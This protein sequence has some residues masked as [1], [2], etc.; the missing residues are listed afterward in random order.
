MASLTVLLSK[1]LEI[2]RIGEPAR[3]SPWDRSVRQDLVTEQ[4]QKIFMSDYINS[5]S[6]VHGDEGRVLKGH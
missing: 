6:S 4:Q 5:E 1:L 2:V 3:C